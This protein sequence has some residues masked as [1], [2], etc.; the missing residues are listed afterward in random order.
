MSRPTHTGDRC[1]KH[2]I[3]LLKQVHRTKLWK[4][5][6]RLGPEVYEQHQTSRETEDVV[7]IMLQ[8]QERSFEYTVWLVNEVLNL[9]KLVFYS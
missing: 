7:I 2:E 9:N 3:A 8:H 4:V 5:N 6:T 1:N